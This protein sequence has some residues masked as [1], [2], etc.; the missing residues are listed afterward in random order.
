MVDLKDTGK[1][2]KDLIELGKMFEQDSITFAKANGDYYLIS[3]NKC[4]EG[5]PGEGKIGVE[6]KL[7][8]PQFGKANKDTEKFFSK[9]RGRGFVFK[10]LGESLITF[11]KLSNNEKYSITKIAENFK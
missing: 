6:V 7:G 5:Y 1:L 3:T 10:S 11:E 4:P 2:K 9:I 8:K